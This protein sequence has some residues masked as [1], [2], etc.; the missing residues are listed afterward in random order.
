M[1]MFKRT[2]LALGILALPLSA[3]AQESA[4]VWRIEISM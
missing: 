1:K 2:I 4:S 3:L